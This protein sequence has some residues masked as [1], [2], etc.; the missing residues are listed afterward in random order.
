MDLFNF[1]GVPKDYDEV[2]NKLA[3]YNFCILTITLYLLDQDLTLGTKVLGKETI[4][5][6]SKSGKLLSNDMGPLAP[7]IILSFITALILRVA[8]WYDL[9]TDGFNIRFRF[10]INHVV[11]PLFKI[12]RRSVTPAVY[13]KIKNKR[14]EIMGAVFYRYASFNKPEIDDQLVSNAR[15]YWYWF[16]VTLETSAIW[17]VLCLILFL[18]AILTGNDVY[19]NKAVSLAY[20]TITA[21][22]MLIPQA[23]RCVRTARRQITEVIKNV[24][25]RKNIK[26][27][28]K[29]EI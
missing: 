21:L 27:Y 19:F 7:A 28:F 9:L 6:F 10:D 12:T 16:W 11:I 18:T 25:R 13:K 15:D 1:F 5:L 3:F 4:N 17:L 29:N 2:I 8:R 22:L 23:W 20:C 14:R 24:S 26:D